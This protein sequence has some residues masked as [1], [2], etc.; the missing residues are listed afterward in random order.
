MP[1]E[2]ITFGQKI[3]KMNVEEIKLNGFIV[4]YLFHFVYQLYDNSSL[5]S[6]RTLKNLNNSKTV[7]PKRNLISPKLTR[8]SITQNIQEHSFDINSNYLPQVEKIY[9]DFENKAYQFDN[10]NLITISQYY[11]KEIAKKNENRNLNNN[12][13]S[14]TSSNYSENEESKSNSFSDSSFSYESS[15]FSSSEDKN[16][17]EHVLFK[18]NTV[19]KFSN[20]VDEFY[21]VNLT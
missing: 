10:K 13:S 12:S 15:S 16:K 3:F 8:K 6:K 19:N 7:S 1:E 18:S 4:G 11:N 17:N 20:F 2:I 14:M 9:F 21:K 5:I